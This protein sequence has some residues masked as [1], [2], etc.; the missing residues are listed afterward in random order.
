MAPLNHWLNDVCDAVQGLVDTTKARDGLQ[1]VPLMD[2]VGAAVFADDLTEA[3]LRDAANALK[4]I[5]DANAYAG[6]QK[7]VSSV[8]PKP[9]RSTIG[10][11]PQPVA[12][13]M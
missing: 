6:V 5:A 4:S 9:A 13:A 2:G 11:K 1:R 7:A 10:K 3:E 8:V 12:V